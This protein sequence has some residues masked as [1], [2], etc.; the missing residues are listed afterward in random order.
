MGKVH[1]IIVIFFVALILNSP[2][3][4]G[5]DINDGLVAFYPFNGNAQDLSGYNNHGTVFGAI[6]VSD[7]FGNANSAFLFDG[8]DD[9]IDVPHSPLL[10]SG[11][12]TLSAWI[13]TEYAGNK[14]IVTK[15]PLCDSDENG[16]GLLLRTG[17]YVAFVVGTECIGGHIQSVNPI[18]TDWVHIA[19]VK[20]G[21]SIYLYVDGEA[22]GPGSLG[23]AHSIFTS[24]ADFRIGMANGGHES[25]EGQIDDVSFYNRALSEAEIRELAGFNAY[26]CDDDNDGYYDVASDGYCIGEGCRPSRCQ[27]AP[28]NDCDDTPMSGAV[29]Y[30]GAPEICDRLD[31]NCN[32][33]VDEGLDQVNRVSGTVYY[34]GSQTGNILVAAVD[35]KNNFSAVAQVI[36]VQPGPYSL[37][38]PSGTF[39][40]VAQM[41][42]DHSG[43]ISIE[44]FQQ[45]KPSGHTDSGCAMDDDAIVFPGCALENMD[46]YLTDFVEASILHKSVP[47][48][49]FSGYGGDMGYNDGDLWICD[50]TWTGNSFDIHQV[51]PANG[52]LVQSFDLNIDHVTS[53]EW[54]GN[55]MWVCFKDYSQN[56][57]VVRQYLFDGTAFTPGASYNLPSSMDRDLVWSINIA[58]D[59]NMLWAQERGGCVNIYQIDLSNGSIAGT[60]FAD[61]FGYNKKVDL[62]DITDI[63]FSGGYLWAMDDENPLFVRVEPASSYSI[64]YTFDRSLYAFDDNARYYGMVKHGDIFY[65]LQRTDV[66][67]NEPVSSYKILTATLD[68]CLFKTIDLETI[69]TGFGQTACDQAGSCRGDGDIDNDVDGKD[70]WDVLDCLE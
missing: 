53:L 38:L 49:Y 68:Q 42:T 70:L 24:T 47:V 39:Y 48:D 36:L 50:E 54:I 15:K 3:V 14:F 8:I 5:A 6:P 4:V 20:E 10:L 59:G 9:H 21:N 30:P 67:G 1:I 62:G 33:A 26:Y 32:G 37:D 41:D 34:S 25:F 31:N 16:Y 57:W 7:R 66:E 55:D 64:N 60:I 13:K 44:A 61:S 23:P 51:N 11:D 40:I 43:V 46:I 28:G 12:I 18:G 63:C 19:G 65:L 27:A 29:T 22:R 52:N 56:A 45:N 35:G 69:A 58:W 2:V 17:S